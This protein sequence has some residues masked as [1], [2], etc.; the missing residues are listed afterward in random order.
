MCRSRL[1]LYHLWGLILDLSIEI[2]HSGCRKVDHKVHNV[3][4]GSVQM[5]LEVS[6]KLIL[7]FSACHLHTNTKLKL[8][9]FLKKFKFM[10]WLSRSITKVQTLMQR[11]SSVI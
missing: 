4:I 11:F 9:E 7:F 10:V 1:N 8:R 3:L 2:L 6:W 5:I